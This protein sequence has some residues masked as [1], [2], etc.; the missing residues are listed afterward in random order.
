MIRRR[1]LVAAALLL[2][3]LGACL[4]VHRWT[5]RWG[6]TDE[7]VARALP[8]DPLVPAAELQVTRAITIKAPPAAVW[9]WLVQ[10]GN[11]RAGA[12]SYDI[13]EQLLGLDIH[14]ADEILPEFQDLS[15]G[16]TIPIEDDGSGMEVAILEHEQVLGTLEPDGSFSWTWM[17]LPTAEG[18][19]L[20]SRSRID[21]RSK[22]LLARFVWLGPLVP[23]S[24]IMERKMLL[25]LQ[26]RAERSAH[27]ADEDSAQA[28]STEV[29]AA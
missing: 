26:E 13:V 4:A 28:R 18:T 1:W 12:Y 8:G 25:G 21:A 9:P 15:V 20:L 24:W 16:D 22:P 11:G 19:R 27:A 17:L 6:A 7:E 23:L 14:S 29:A 2:A 10:I 3:D 5:M